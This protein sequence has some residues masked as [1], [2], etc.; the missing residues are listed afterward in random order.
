MEFA[1]RAALFGAK[2]AYL[3]LPLVEKHR[4]GYSVTAN[5]SNFLGHL[6]K[7]L[8]VCRR[9]SESA[10][11]NELLEEIRAAEVRTWRRV[12]REYGERGKRLEVLSAYGRSIR[13]GLS[14]RTLILALLAMLG[15]DALTVVMDNRPKIRQFA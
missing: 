10:G 13:Y 8:Q 6:L 4:D 12:I 5:R 7:A 2:F 1:F 15:P 11:R 14:L 3:D 9:H